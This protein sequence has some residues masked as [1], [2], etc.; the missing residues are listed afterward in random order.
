MR[1]APGESLRTGAFPLSLVLAL[2]VIDSLFLLA[3]IVSAP[4]VLELVE[5][6]RLATTLEE[7]GCAELV[8]SVKP[9][10]GVETYGTVVKAWVS[11][12]KR[13]GG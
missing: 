2:C 10:A 8:G 5:F 12:E 6:R 9:P 4:L 11:L 7:L 1:H 3:N 13:H